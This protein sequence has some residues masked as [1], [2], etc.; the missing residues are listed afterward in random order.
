MSARELSQV[1]AG[2][3][4]LVVIWEAAA[5]ATDA[6]G[7][8]PH[9]TQIVVA[10][11][12]LF[13]EDQLHMD[14]NWTLARAMSS[15]AAAL[16]IG[17]PAGVLLGR[18]PILTRMFEGWLHF[19][20]SIPAFIL[21]PFFLAVLHGGEAAR[22]ATVTFGCSVVIAGYTAL[23]V[24]NVSEL[25]IRVAKLY[26]AGP[27]HIWFRVIFMD[28]LPQT[29]DG[30]RMGLSLALILALVAE[31]MLGA[32]F[33]L[34]TRVNDSLAGFDLPKMYALIIVIGVVGYILNLLAAFVTQ[35]VAPFAGEA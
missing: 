3:T 26:K 32:T 34:G 2:S 9:L 8:I 20:R 10:G 13:Q 15:F 19:F 7:L 35:R 27:W 17:V 21:L 14:I 5:V 12:H 30:V 22:L 16:F 11:W 28:A 33:G 25:R 6:T 29:L 1:L 23:G 24:R 18:V 4:I 31:I